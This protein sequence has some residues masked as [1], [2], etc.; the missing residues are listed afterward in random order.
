MAV[1]ALDLLTAVLEWQPHETHLICMSLGGMVA[2]EMLAML[3]EGSYTP[4]ALPL[5]SSQFQSACLMVTQATGWR[6]LRGLPPLF[7]LTGAFASFLT[8]TSPL[9]RAHTVLA[10]AYN[11][12]FLK[13]PAYLV[14]QPAT[15][16]THPR[17]GQI[18]TNSDVFLR[19]ATKQ[20][21][22]KTSSGF[23]GEQS[24][25]GMLS[26]MSAVATH[27]VSSRRLKQVVSAGTPMLVVGASHDRLVRF[28]NHKR[29]AELLDARK[30]MIDGAAHCVKDE[31]LHEVIQAIMA[32]FQFAETPV[33]P[34]ISTHSSSPSSSSAP[35]N[36]NNHT[37]SSSGN[38]NSDRART[39]A[40]PCSCSMD[41]SAPGT[42][43]RSRVTVMSAL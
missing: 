42:N 19:I 22:E 13:S 34:S 17:T 4:R 8:S 11:K 32:L 30:L 39:G 35:S 28:S 41:Q 5:R 36:Q 23:R 10:V 40:S 2:L 20:Y 37:N 29:L 21:L 14:A 43:P 33:Q 38:N 1:D 25:R 18:L 31:N 7:R 9:E 6:S 12:S 24:F 27:H 3:A 26:Q 16:A 15:L